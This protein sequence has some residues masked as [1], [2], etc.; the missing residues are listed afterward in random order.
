MAENQRLETV[1]LWGL[2]AALTILA[3]LHWAAYFI[4]PAT[5]QTSWPAIPLTGAALAAGIGAFA[6]R[7]RGEK[8]RLM[9]E[10]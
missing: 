9:R 2:T 3:I 5:W 10:S 7:R 8:V 4:G 6:M 1:F